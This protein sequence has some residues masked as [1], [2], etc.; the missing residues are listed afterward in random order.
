[1]YCVSISH[2]TADI[3]VRRKLAFTEKM[4]RRFMSELVGM[5]NA[6]QCAALC[7]CNRT[8][9]YFCGSESACGDVKYLLSK[10]GQTDSCL[11]SPHIRTYSGDKAILH[12]FRVACGIES[13]VVGEDEILGQTKTAYHTAKDN[14]TVSY[15]LNIIFQSAISCAKKIKTCTALSRTSVSTATLAANEAAKLGDR[16]NV[17]VIG[18]TGKIGS[19]VLKNLTSHKNVIVTATLRQH[20]GDVA[21]AAYS[22]VKLENYS[23][24]Y[25]LI[26]SADCIISATSS[27]HYTITYHG[28]K[29]GLHDD[30]QRLFI[31]LA[32]PPDIDSDIKRLDG[33]KLIGIDYFERLARENNA[34]KLDSV[35]AAK[36][37]IAVE[38]DE[39][40]KELYFHDFLPFAESVGKAIADKSFDELLYKLK[41]ELNSQQLKAVLETLKKF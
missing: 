2:K 1:M 37:I 19:T 27:P 10:Y 20:N 28:L 5:G 34:L 13:M 15:E 16:V 32:V 11:L 38:A 25:S 36:Q 29:N 3:S 30:R 18:A 26:K 39:L 7:T 12:L 17:L 22:G 31:D 9:I 8:E 23:E 4:Q 21:P 33:V 41:S 14:G 35:E 24:R 40:Q 6:V